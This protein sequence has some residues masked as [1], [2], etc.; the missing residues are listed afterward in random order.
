MS[1][2]EDN[3]KEIYPVTRGT[4]ANFANASDRHFG[5]VT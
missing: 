1:L 3:V 2:F 5:D 4:P